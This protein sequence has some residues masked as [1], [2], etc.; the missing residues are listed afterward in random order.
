MFL[1]GGAAPA[2]LGQ[3]KPA[4]A[5]P[6]IVL[7][8]AEDLGAWLLGCFGNKEIQTP[9]LDLLCRGGSRFTSHT[10]V[11]T[12]CA[13]GR[14]TLLTGRLPRQ[15]GIED[16]PA[17][18]RTE[19]LL[20]D[21][22][23]SR[24]YECGYT[25]V[26]GLGEEEKP[27]HGFRVWS[28]QP[29]SPTSRAVQFLEAQKKEQPFFLVVSHPAPRAP[30]GGHAA[31]FD[32]M[33]AKTSFDSLAWLPASDNAAEG[34]EYLKD[35]IGSVRKLAASVTALDSEIPPLISVLDKRGLRDRT[36]V[37]FTSCTG[38]LAGR[39]GLWNGGRGSNPPNL[40]AEG[41][42]TPM[43]WN[44]PGTVPV[45]G[46]RAE[47]AASYDLFPSLCEVAGVAPP[48]DRN[49]CGR[50]YLLPIRNRPLPRRQAWRS[51]VFAACGNT[52]MARDP[53]FKLV[54]RNQGSG[55]NELYDIRADARE[56]DNQYDNDGFLSV[57]T[58]LT[59]AIRQ[60]REKYV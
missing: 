50:S 21:L 57:R 16:S 56:L 48:K 23:A 29:D 32:E 25:G 34:R 30:Y 19:V 35:Y 6:N 2:L 10:S 40:F 26:W 60:W 47:L 39:H 1:A 46:A 52:E 31:K 43:I 7:I 27:Q 9:N 41:V 51:V 36:L 59:D 58:A 13:S 5:P 11:T 44:W 18:F 33:Y 53:R 42:E 38:L 12:A 4:E 55:P 15:H 8:L 17:K 14:A 28:T 20:S 45:E 54:L 3:R 24:G 49:L 22:L 37:V